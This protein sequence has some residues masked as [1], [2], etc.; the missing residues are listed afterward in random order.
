MFKYYSQCAIQLL[1]KKIIL[2]FYELKIKSFCSKI[3]IGQQCTRKILAIG[4]LPQSNIQITSIHCGVLIKMFPSTHLLQT[5][6][7]FSFYDP[8][9]IFGLHHPR[10][11]ENVFSL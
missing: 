2:N 6:V 3:K 11:H 8:L 7:E 5:S 10:D 1:F 4:R 9:A